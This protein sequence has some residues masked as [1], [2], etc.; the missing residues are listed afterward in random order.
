MTP[1]TR[2]ISHGQLGRRRTRD[3]DRR[4]GGRR[5]DYQAG[6]DRAQ[7]PCDAVGVV[8]ARRAWDA[9]VPVVADSDVGLP[10][11]VAGPIVGPVAD[12][13]LPDTLCGTRVTGDTL[14]GV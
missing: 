3:R 2:P 8:A 12:C 1:S 7:R 10:A 4:R 13:V 6:R 5:D 11:A 14:C 9:Q